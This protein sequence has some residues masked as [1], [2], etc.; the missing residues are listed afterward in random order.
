[1]VINTS[2]AL[3]TFR[4]TYL[5]NR[6]VHSRLIP[7]KTLH[8][9]E[10]LIYAKRMVSQKENVLRLLN[11]AASRWLILNYFQSQKNGKPMIFYTRWRRHF[12][13][14]DI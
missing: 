9:V 13:R 11:L 5:Y 14:L 4:E 3:Y 1:M 8:V 12:T 6:W 10:L 2:Y 7:I